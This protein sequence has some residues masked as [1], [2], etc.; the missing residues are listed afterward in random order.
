MMSHQVNEQ[1][2]KELADGDSTPASRKNGLGRTVSGI[3]VKDEREERF[4]PLG[5]QEATQTDEGLIVYQVDAG[6]GTSLKLPALADPPIITEGEND[7]LQVLT[8]SGV[9]KIKLE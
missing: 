8:T 1:W 4:V 6:D 5:I 9:R 2:K 7:Y 3:K